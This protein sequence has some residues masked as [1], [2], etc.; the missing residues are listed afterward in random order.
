MGP[1]KNNDYLQLGD[2]GWNEKLA[3]AV[4]II[5]ILAIGVAPFWLTDLINPGTDQIMQKI[6]TAISN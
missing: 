6:T 5:G 1:V 4:L 2:A 3:A